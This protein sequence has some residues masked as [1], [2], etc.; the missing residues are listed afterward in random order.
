LLVFSDKMNVV[1]RQGD[2]VLKCRTSSFC[3]KIQSWSVNDRSGEHQYWCSIFSRRLTAWV[4]LFLSLTHC[5]SD[6]RRSSDFEL[7]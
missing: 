6:S 1:P 4:L 5:L 2:R 7:R 3:F